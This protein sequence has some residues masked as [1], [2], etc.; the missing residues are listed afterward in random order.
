MLLDMEPVHREAVYDAYWVFAA[1]RQAI[2]ERR[3]AGQPWPWTADPILR[4]FK[5]CNAFRAS[6]RVSQFLIRRVAYADDVKALAPEDVFLRVILFR[7]FSKETTWHLLEASTGGV[8]RSTLDVGRMGDVLDDARTRGP[9][10]TSAFILAPERKGGSKH[11]S[12]LALI[13]EMFRGGDLG[14][15]IAHAGSLRAVY[16]AL[17]AW[18]MIGPF[19]AY[20][21]AVDLNYTGHLNFDEDDFTAPGPGAIRGLRK[22]FADFGRNSPADL[23]HYMVE[24]QERE[25]DRLGLQFDGLFGRRL[26]AID[27]QGLFCEIDK[28]SRQAFPA[29][30]SERVRIKHR[31]EASG[32]P[33]PLFY[34]P[35]WE[36]NDRLPSTVAPLQQ[37]LLLEA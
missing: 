24:R 11:R 36:I 23:I 5:F 34:P 21:L 10:Y 17:I 32:K 4:K 22:V 2:F 19:L 31:F 6:D 3:V 37:E 29:L 30:K 7:L 9:I 14:R 25:F 8:C 33:L 1:E 35:K 28:Y 18:P 27:C 20:Q 16:E 12:H 26:H 13:S 15:Q